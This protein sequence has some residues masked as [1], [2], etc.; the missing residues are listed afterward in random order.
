M[1]QTIAHYRVLG[2]LGSGS[3]GEV[4]KAEDLKL[5]RTVAIKLLKTTDDHAIE[6]IKSEARMAA[7][8]NHPNVATVYELGEVGS[9]YYLAFEW[10]EGQTL[11]DKIKHGPLE[12]NTAL[13]I[14]IQIADALRI[15]HTRGLLHCDL[16]SLNIMI[17]PADSVKVL[18]FG[19]ARFVSTLEVN[20][21]LAS[22]A[23]Q[24]AGDATEKSGRCDTLVRQTFAGTPGYVSPE[25][26]R[27]EPLDGRTDIFSLGVVLYEMLTT[28]LPFDGERRLD[29]LHSTLV[30]EL[31]LLSSFREDVPLELE[32][33]IRKALARDRNQRYA[34]VDDLLSDLHSLK[35]R[36]AY[37]GAAK[38]ESTDVSVSAR[39]DESWT[40][41][42]STSSLR[43]LARKWRRWLLAAGV[44][45]GAIAIGIF[46]SFSHAAPN[47]QAR[48]AFSPSPYCAQSPTLPDESWIR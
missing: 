32:S 45:V 42:E 30:D 40:F 20:R 37:Q 7:T 33:I 34:V 4:W 31:P 11:L 24:Q 9:A 29:A 14:S 38:L 27:C 16:K 44:F 12:L 6:R 39:P 2:V 5:R 8:L 18:D 48:S 13:A 17:T 41:S 3:S 1:D 26:I 15:A 10:V 47:W 22:V 21:T 36:L 23:I 28:R 35:D 19:L 25:Q 46:W 43:W